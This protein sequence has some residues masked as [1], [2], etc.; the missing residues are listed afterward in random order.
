MERGDRRTSSG[1]RRGKADRER[2][3][4]SKVQ[5]GGEHLRLI[6]EAAAL[7]VTD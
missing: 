6:S 7:K 1:T 3:Q 4:V 5:T 2:W